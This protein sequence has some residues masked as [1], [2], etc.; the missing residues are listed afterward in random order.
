MYIPYFNKS[1]GAII[2][3]I[4]DCIYLTQKANKILAIM[5]RVNTIKI[6]LGSEYLNTRTCKKNK[7]TKSRQQP[8]TCYE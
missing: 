8:R 2:F 7:Q 3:P 6:T 1:L 5:Y 4:G